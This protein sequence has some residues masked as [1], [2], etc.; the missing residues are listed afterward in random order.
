MISYLDSG[1]HLC[2]VKGRIEK[3]LYIVGTATRD[4]CVFSFQCELEK[5]YVVGVCCSLY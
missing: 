5:F 4:N 2:E 3:G 1:F